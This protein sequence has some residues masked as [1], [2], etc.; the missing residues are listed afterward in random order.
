MGISGENIKRAILGFA[1]CGSLGLS[2][3]A[4]RTQIASAQTASS[5]PS[6]YYCSKYYSSYW[7]Y[8]YGFYKGT[9]ITNDLQN[10]EGYDGYNYGTRWY[11][12]YYPD[13]QYWYFYN[14]QPAY[15]YKYYNSYKYRCFT[16]YQ[17]SQSSQSYQPAPTATPSGY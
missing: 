14:T 3:P 2:V 17:S 8:A 4:I 1:I 15:T 11:Q 6:Y 13:P 16:P 5:H 12:G 9:D 7:G 10:H